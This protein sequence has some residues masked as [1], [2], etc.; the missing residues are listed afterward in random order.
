MTRTIAITRAPAATLAQCE[1]TFRERTPIDVALARRQHDAYEHALRSLGIEVVRLPPR[2][3]WPDSVFIEDA[4]L[5]LDEVAVIT[6]PGAPTRVAEGAAL[7]DTLAHFR[8]LRHITAPATL[9]GGDVVRTGR[10]LYVGKS[11]RTNDAGRA[12]LAAITGP[13]GYTV[14]AVGMRD[15]LHLKTACSA[16]R[17]GLVLADPARIRT[18]DLHHIAIVPVPPAESDA[19]DVLVIG[20]TVLLP[21][22][23][24]ATRATLRE[25]GFAVLEV[26]LSEFARAEGGPTCLSLVFTTSG[27]P[28]NH[29]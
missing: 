26:D 14:H 28:R 9:D 6:R 16:L 25:N 20:N 19:A 29:R 27:S 2:D 3:E 15:C 18:A 13:L 11:T 7:E 23:Y 5:V 4:A 8:P 22:G 1:L 21:A 17:D 12:Q 10:A 24:P